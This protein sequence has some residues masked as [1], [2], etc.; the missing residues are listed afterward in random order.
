MFFFWKS[1]S[2]LFVFYLSECVCFLLVVLIYL[3]PS[4]QPETKRNKMLLCD[5]CDA[6]YH[7]KCL[8]LYE[9]CVV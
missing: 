3:D 5:T 9:V 7:C 6:E 2:L 4:T 8:G 1:R